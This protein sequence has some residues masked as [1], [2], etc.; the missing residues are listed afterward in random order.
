M[1]ENLNFSLPEKKR[2]SSFTS[3]IIIILLLILVVLG[4]INLFANPSNQGILNSNTASSLTPEQVKQLAA[5]LT[6]RNLYLQA[7]KVWQDYLEANK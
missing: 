6:A 1:E 5:K 7:A 3:K 2:K 4:L